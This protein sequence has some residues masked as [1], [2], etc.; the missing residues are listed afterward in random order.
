MTI[1]PRI[2]LVGAGPWAQDLLTL[3]GAT[4]LRKADVVIYDYLVN[5]AHLDHVQPSCEC[6]CVGR[7]PRRM[8]QDQIHELM[9][10][11]AKKD[12]RVVRLKGGDPFIFGRGGEEAEILEKHGIPFEVVPGITTALAAA[13]YAGVSLTHRDIC[14]TVTFVTGHEKGEGSARKPNWSALVQLDTLVLYMAAG[15]IR[16]IA[17]ELIDHGKPRETR[18]AF[19][20]WVS[21][22]TQ[23]TQVMS[24]S[25][26]LAREQDAL[27]KAPVLI[28]IGDVVQENMRLNWFERRPLH[29]RRILVTRSA[30][31]QKALSQK[32]SELGAEPISVPMIETQPIEGD[33]IDQM[34]AELAQVDWVIFTS[35]NAV[36]FFFRGLFS[37]EKDV[38]ALSHAKF[39]CVGPVT[40]SRLRTFGLLADLIPEA[41]ISEGLLKMFP[42]DLRGQR[43]LLPR[44]AIARKELP[45]E[46]M[47]RGARVDDIATY[48]TIPVELSEDEQTLIRT[49]HFDAITFTS[50]STVRALERWLSPDLGQDLKQNVPAFCIGP[51]TRKTADQCGYKHTYSGTEYSLEGL[52]ENILKYL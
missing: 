17:Q 15:S 9:I 34:Y 2:A 12:Q 8:S 29:G 11:A 41:Y 43:F 49:T 19:V 38:R 32:L 26:V 16:R 44:A 13:A 36:D 46:L 35:A 33:E 5:R 30:H 21:R 48:Q 22:N 47:A 10:A 42:Q 20:Q 28:V 1:R 7:P 18:A 37:R 25:D 14:S 40:Q 51:A 52:T 39:A 50:S 23:S 31:Q 24:L 27:P 45:A 3:R 6:V 4:L